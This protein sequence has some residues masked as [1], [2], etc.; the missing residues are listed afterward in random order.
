MNKSYK[1][2]FDNSIISILFSVFFLFWYSIFLFTGMQRN[3]A[4]LSMAFVIFQILSDKNN[5]K[6]KKIISIN[7][8]FSVIYIFICGVSTLYAVSGKFAVNEFSNIISA[9]GIFMLILFNIKDGK[10]NIFNIMTILSSVSAIFSVLS[11]DAASIRILTKVYLKILSFFEIKINIE[12]I[13]FEKATRIMSIFGNANILAGILAI[14][15]FLSLYLTLKSDTKFK[16]LFFI[17]LLSVNSLGFLLAFS[18]GSIVMFSLSAII[19]L[20]SC[21]KKEKLKTFLLMTETFFIT[22]LTAFLAFKGL[23]KYDTLF[24]V[25]PIL[26]IFLNWIFLY[27]LN[28]IVEKSIENIIIKNQKTPFPFY[29]VITIFLLI[30]AILSVNITGSADITK[31]DKL[32]RSVYPKPGTYKIITDTSEGNLFLKIE[33]QN[34][35]EIMMHKS[36]SIYN[37]KADNA[38]FTVP[39]NSKIVNFYFSTDSENL[40]IKSAVYYN[41]NFSQKI[42]L[43]YLLMPDFAAN[44]IQGLKVNQNAAQRFIFFAD[45]IKLFKT[46]PILGLGLGGFEN[47]IKS[48]QDFYYETKYVHNHYIQILIDTGIVGLVIFLLWIISIF[49]SLIKRNK[50]NIYSEFYPVMLSCVVM[51]TLHALVEVIFSIGPYLIFVY[52]I[53]AIITY[54]YS[55]N[56]LKTSINILKPIKGFLLIFFSLFLLFFAGNKIAK[57]KIRNIENKSYVNYKNLFETLKTASYMDVFEKNDYL[58]SYVVNSVYYDDDEILK[59]SNKIAEK[60]LNE[61]SNSIQNVLSDYYFKIG[62]IKKAFEASKIAIDYTKSNPKT[63][64]RQFDIFEQNFNILRANNS[65]EIK[66][67]NEKD[68]Y[69][70]NIIEIYK[71]LQSENEERME[72]IKLTDKNNIYIGKILILNELKLNDLNQY[73]DVFVNILFDSIKFS[74]CDKNGIPDIIKVINGNIINNNGVFEISKDTSFNISLVNWLEGNYVMEFEC[75]NP[76]NIKSIKWNEQEVPFVNDQ[77]KAYYFINLPQNNAQETFT[78]NIEVNDSIKIKRILIKKQ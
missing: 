34:I 55:E 63:W 33:S 32:K 6:L 1:I 18:M 8:I 67:L 71:K 48:V 40:K 42:K 47:G 77:E 44:R 3:I 72:K 70:K 2:K 29:F 68:I 16:K 12:D 43:K 38:E 69:I 78:F 21:S 46:S 19:Y 13:G 37:G 58:L 64:Q 11:I 25:L 23:G 22:L 31:G 75:D 14:G 30:Y 26:S 76:K 60:L 61:K 74:D 52:S 9:F 51:M 56:Y 28:N 17:L 53:F 62:N 4:I 20:I 24:S 15:I 35:Q 7:F 36:L 10:K 49:T 50:N 65:E 45:G 41:D 73:A 54:C 27:F 39:E 59:E 5:F 57:L 66:K